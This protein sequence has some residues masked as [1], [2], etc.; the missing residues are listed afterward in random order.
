MIAVMSDNQEKERR[1]VPTFFKGNEGQVVVL[2][3]LLSLVSGNEAA[4]IVGLTAAVAVV[5]EE[6]VRRLVQ[7]IGSKKR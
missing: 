6:P 2:G 3:G 5:A 4:A 7:K 1:E